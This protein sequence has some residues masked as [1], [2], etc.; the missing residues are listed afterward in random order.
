MKLGLPL[1][2]AV[3]AKIIKTYQEIFDWQPNNPSIIFTF[4]AFKL[5]VFVTSDVFFGGA[6][7]VSLAF[8][9]ILICVS[10][11]RRE[12]KQPVQI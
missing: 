3:C 11:P 9:D 1:K 6:Q 4:L 5:G 7:F 10:L 8:F 12:K 2:N